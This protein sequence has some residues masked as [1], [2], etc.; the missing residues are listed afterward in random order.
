MNY[1]VSINRDRQLWMQAHR[2][3]DALAVAGSREPLFVGAWSF[4]PLNAPLDV[5]IDDLVVDTK[6]VSCPAQ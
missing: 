6:P 5:W 2:W 3:L 1:N 4:H